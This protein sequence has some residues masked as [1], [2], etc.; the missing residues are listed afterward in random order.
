MEVFPTDVN[1]AISHFLQRNLLKA[2]IEMH[3]WYCSASQSVQGELSCCFGLPVA[4]RGKVEAD[5][6]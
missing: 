1:T 2:S 3:G 4:S 5:F 6:A